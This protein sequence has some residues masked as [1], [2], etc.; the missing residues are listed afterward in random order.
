MRFKNFQI[1]KA[2][3]KRRDTEEYDTIATQIASLQEQV[4]NKTKEL[5]VTR[6]QLKE[7][8]NTVPDIDVDKEPPPQPHGPL[9]ELTIEAEDKQENEET[10]AVTSLEEVDGEVPVVEVIKTPAAA[11][12]EA[13]KK[14]APAEEKAPEKQAE[15]DSLANLFSQEDEEA[16]PLAALINSL[17][18][19]TPQ[20]LLDDLQE[21]KEIIKEQ[22]HH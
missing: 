21:I 12:T 19:V 14:E 3:E 9:G 4:N 13:G 1:G 8:S 11:A 7:L 18:D 22:Q 10:D 6:Q 17:P 20:E 5:E 2:K 15:D 16:N